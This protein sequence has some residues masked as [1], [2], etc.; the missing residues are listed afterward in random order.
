MFSWLMPPNNNFIGLVQK[1]LKFKEIFTQT[2]IKFQW[3]HKNL[4]VLG[5]FQLFLVASDLCE[6]GGSSL[7]NFE[8]VQRNFDK[9]SW[10]S[11][12]ISTIN[13][14][15]LP[16]KAY[17]KPHE[18]GKQGLHRKS[19][20]SWGQLRLQRKATEVLCQRHHCGEAGSIK[21]WI[22]SELRRGEH[23]HVFLLLQ[24]PPFIWLSLKISIVKWLNIQPV[25][26]G[27]FAIFPY[28]FLG[29]IY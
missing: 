19:W 27:F 7:G 28:G 3:K 22:P 23:W 17:R 1:L 25:I 12:C 24:A 13:T 5:A 14:I 8:R 11:V 21:G 15:G 2:A 6:T 18:D 26:R 4:S 20:T 16:F 29:N 10:G 9:I